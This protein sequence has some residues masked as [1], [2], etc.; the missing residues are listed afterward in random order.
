MAAE[1]LVLNAEVAKAP[2]H[3][4]LDVQRL[5]ALAHEPRVAR[6]DELADLGRQPGVDDGPRERR[7][8]GLDVERLL[9]AAHAPRVA[10]LEHLADLVVALA[11]GRGGGGAAARGGGAPPPPAA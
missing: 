10:S 8:L 11:G 6:L 4:G 1:R 5:L 9:A 3:L 2:C 7:Q